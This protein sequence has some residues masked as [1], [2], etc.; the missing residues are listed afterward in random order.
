MTLVLG[1]DGSRDGWVAIRMD[2]TMVLGA[3][4]YPDFGAL[5]NAEG[6]AAVV[7]VDMP[8]GL[9]T[10]DGWPRAA[11]GAARAFI[12]RMRSSVFVVPPAEAL[13]APTHAEAVQRCRGAGIPG[14]SQQAYALRHKVFEV[15]EHAADPR[16]HEV[17]PEVSFAAMNGGHLRHGKRTWN[18]CQERMR[19][20][21]RAGITIPDE[22]GGVGRAGVDDVLDAA[23]AGWSATRIALGEA[24]HLPAEAPVGTPRI[25]Y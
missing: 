17:H 4:T 7:A 13:G 21:A 20:L 15:A 22:L 12:G 11:D 19:I 9:P 3:A 16:V 1:V 10:A 8:I 24:G 14:L 23:A 6:E 18:G 25:W 5:L 2:G